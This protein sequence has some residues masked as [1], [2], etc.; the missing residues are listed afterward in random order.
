MLASSATASL[1]TLLVLVAACDGAEDEAPPTSVVVLSGEPA[2]V[3]GEGGA[4]NATYTAY[5]SSEGHPY[6][7]RLG[8]RRF[9]GGAPHRIVI[10]LREP[11]AVGASYEIGLEP[12]DVLL[13]G[14]ATG[15]SPPDVT[16][17]LEG[18]AARNN[19]PR[20]YLASSGVFEVTALTD[21]TIAGRFSAD[22]LRSPDRIGDGR[23][24]PVLGRAEGAFVAEEH[25]V[26]LL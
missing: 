5:P 21:S 12:V 6:R 13:P 14:E 11:P 10:V 23:Y 4:V 9:E 19:R 7:I 22:L 15:G 3:Y 25:R 1:L 17:S 18:S 24:T 16:L 8:F 2:E 26:V 20:V